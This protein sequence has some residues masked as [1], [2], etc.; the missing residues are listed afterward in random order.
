MLFS[1]FQKILTFYKL[2]KP[3]CDFGSLLALQKV[4]RFELKNSYKKGI[5]DFS[6]SALKMCVQDKQTA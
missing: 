5:L 1:D 6:T 3:H 2:L 4:M